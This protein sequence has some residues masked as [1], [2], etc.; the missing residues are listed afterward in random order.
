MAHHPQTK[1]ENGI[2][3]AMASSTGRTV[4]CNRN[5]KA[6]GRTKEGMSR[7]SKRGNRGMMEGVVF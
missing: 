6:A 5:R 7:T 3:T 1:R 4:F 2:E